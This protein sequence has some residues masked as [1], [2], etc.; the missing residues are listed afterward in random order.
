MAEQ[1]NLSR[2]SRV[3]AVVIAAVCLLLILLVPVLFARP[4]EQAVRILCAANL[5]QI[6]K[7]MLMYAGD[8]DGVLPRAGGPSTVWGGTPNCR[9]ACSYAE[10]TRE[11][12]SSD[13]P[14]VPTVYRLSNS[15]TSGISVRLPR[16]SG[17]AATRTTSRSGRLA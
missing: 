13:L 14:F 9:R 7:A 2:L 4:R 6:G 3:D 11:Q 17:I 12:S 8:N 5:A 1:R 10:V 16:L 15:S